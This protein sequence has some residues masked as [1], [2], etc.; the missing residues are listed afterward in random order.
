MRIVTV[1]T[2]PRGSFDKIIN[3][4]FNAHVD[5]LGW[6][7]KW[8]GYKMKGELMLKYL[9][10]LDENEIVVYIDGFDSLINRDPSE[11]EEI[12]K[13]MNV[14]ILTSGEPCNF[15]HKLNGW[16]CKGK[17]HANAGM[18]MGYAKYVKELLMKIMSSKCQ[19]DQFL[20]NKYYEDFEIDG[21]NIIFENFLAKSIDENT[22]SKAFFV[23]F[24][25]TYT[26]DRLVIRGVKEYSQFMFTELVVVFILSAWLVP[27]K[28][29]MIPITSFVLWYLYIDKGCIFL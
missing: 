21:N 25:F 26:F 27:G 18:Y 9:E 15:T 10:D 20:L 4:K 3:N 28:Y 17:V 19:D 11:V 22:K 2:D 13:K 7:Q 29:K 12:F 16:N 5:V 1:A 14:K 23:S 8:T 24:P 6:G